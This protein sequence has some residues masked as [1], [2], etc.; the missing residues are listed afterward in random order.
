[1][2]HSDDNFLQ[3]AFVGEVR[4]KAPSLAYGGNRILLH[5]Q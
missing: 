1:M 3:K 2:I 5:A 4:D